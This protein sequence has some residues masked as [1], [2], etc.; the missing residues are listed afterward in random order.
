MAFKHGI[1]YNEKATSIIPTLTA[2]APTV[3]IGVAPIHLATDPAPVNTPV[4]CNTYA[5]YV[6]AFGHS[7]E[8]SRYTICEAAYVHF[9]LYNVRPVIFINVLDPAKH[10][11]SK[12]KTVT[13]LSNTVKVDCNAILTTLTVTSGEATLRKGTD[14]TA[15]Y[16]DEGYL[17]FTVTSSGRDKLTG[18]S[19]TLSYNGVKPELVTA[20]DIIG[21]VDSTT[22]K[23]KGL[24]C[25]NDVYPKYGVLS[26]CVIAPKYST[27]AEVAAVMAAKVTNI[28]GC[29][30]TICAVDLDTSTVKKYSD[31][32]TAKN[33][34]NLVDKNQIVCFP[35]V[36]LGN[37]KYHLSTHVAAIMSRTDAGNDDIPFESPSNK[38]LQAEGFCLADGT[39]IL[40]AKDQADWLNSVGIVCGLN[41]NGYRLFGNY[42]SI[43]PS[44]TDSKDVFIAV[45]RMMNY[46]GSSI[47]LTFFSF[48]D[49]PISRRLIEVVES[50]VQ[51]FLN[52][53][54][55]SEC[56]LG[57]TVTFAEEDNP[58][59]ELIAGNLKFHLDVTFVVPAQCIQFEIEFDP[60]AYQSLF[61]S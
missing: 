15:A 30:N 11:E 24:E 3:C 44:V 38:S 34:N 16:D 46:I 8:F 21:G 14:Y 58:L 53:L 25:I 37:E 54:A 18:D 56:I 60:T 42:T 36:A 59:I 29:F 28:N 43:Y 7:D 39:E 48:V 26:G 19:A 27:D 32:Y 23:N 33:A 35:M 55:A 61:S 22:G 4:L 10:T 45:R 40:I 12:S 52:G 20:A 41:M 13:G 47:I 57:G 6:A 31:A 2:A 49:A 5:E 9:A 17:E 1:F 50:S 51:Q